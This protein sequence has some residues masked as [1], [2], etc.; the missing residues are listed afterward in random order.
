MWRC[1]LIA[2]KRCAR[3]TSWGAMCVRKCGSAT[4]ACLRQK[5]K[6]IWALSGSVR[7][8]I[9]WQKKWKRKFLQI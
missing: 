2:W 8:V 9:I 6:L 7:N 5:K 3:S 4:T 1:V